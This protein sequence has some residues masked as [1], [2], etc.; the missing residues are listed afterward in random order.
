MDVEVLGRSLSRDAYPLQ[1]WLFCI[2]GQ[3]FLRSDGTE[4]ARRYQSLCG[5]R[6][7]PIDA[8]TV[9]QLVHATAAGTAE[10]LIGDGWTRCSAEVF[11]RLFIR[12]EIGGTVDDIRFVPRT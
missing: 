9:E 4:S 11:A 7:W 10:E 8:D 3:A 12:V 5:C 1:G 2:C 6:L